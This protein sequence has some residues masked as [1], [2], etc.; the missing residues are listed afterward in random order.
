MRITERYR[1][2]AIGKI[3]NGG[4]QI[5]EVR[6]PYGNV[7]GSK[8]EAEDWAIRLCKEWIDEEEKKSVS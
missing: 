8:K 2:G 7:V 1:W 3:L 6:T 5:K 4:R